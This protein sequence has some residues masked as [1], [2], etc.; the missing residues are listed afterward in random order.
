MTQPLPRTAQGPTLV[1]DNQPVAAQGGIARRRK[2]RESS[3]DDCFS[4]LDEAVT[5]CEV[6]ALIHY[7][8]ERGLDPEGKILVALYE[9]VNR[10][11]AAG[12]GQVRLDAGKETLRH[13]AALTGITAKDNVNGRTLHEARR[14]GRHLSKIVV[15]GLV[16]LFLGVC[17]ETLPLFA[18]PLAAGNGPVAQALLE[19]LATNSLM[20]LNPFFWGAVGS[21]VFLMKR[22][23]D[24]AAA[25]SFDS[26][27]L[28]GQGARIF[29]G[30][31]FA[32]IVVNGFG[33]HGSGEVAGAPSEML[34]LTSA[35]VGFL[36]GLGVKVIYGAFERLVEARRR[37]GVGRASAP[38]RGVVSARHRRPA[39]AGCRGPGSVARFN[40]SRKEAIHDP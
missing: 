3:S 12:D 25:G 39:G 33:L 7:A 26:R 1:T 22:L 4:S 6:N 18:K 35:G 36:C 23:S 14:V 9:A 10:L 16:S 8:S 28:Q 34:N 40:P 20:Y 15:L 11:E 5:V 38:R 17:V 32:G 30:A 13:Y 31:A 27:Q 21:C 2:R 37:G 29:L 24:L 19:L